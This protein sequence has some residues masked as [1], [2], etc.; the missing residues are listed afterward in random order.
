MVKVAIDV[1]PLH[2]HRTG[3]GNA[4]AWTIEAFSDKDSGVT[5]IELYQYLTSMRARRLKTQ[6]RIPIPAAMALRMWAHRSPPIDWM[7]GSP[8]LVHGTN[9]VVPPT[10]CP[11]LVSVYD[12]WFLD[13]PGDAA[14]DVQ[15]AGAVLRHAVDGGAHVVTSSDATT[16]RARELLSTDRVRT[17]HLGPPAPLA[18]TW[19]RPSSLPDLGTNPFVLSLGTLERRKNVPTLI[20]AFARLAREHGSVRLVIAGAVGN[21]L[22]PITRAIAKLDPAVAERVLRTGPVDQQTKSW[23]LANARTL[24]Y[25]S[26]DEG[27]GFP[28]LEAQQIGTPV[29]ASTAGSIPE[30]AGSAALLSPPLDSEALAANLFWVLTNDDMHAK[31]IRLGR[32][33]LLRFSWATTAEQLAD[34]YRELAEL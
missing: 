31:L 8:D 15:R 33:N 14:A 24:A 27:F 19:S 11:Q 1:G 23:L 28:I 2:G 13:R 16:E 10:A 34:T 30:V 22:E 21:D 7:I 9:Y 3:I 32:S 26:L 12:C 25:P 17:I 6:R 29:V 20:A 5:D 4:V 18:P